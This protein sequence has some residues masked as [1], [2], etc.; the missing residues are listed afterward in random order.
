MHPYPPL[1]RTWT[2]LR[3]WLTREYPELGDTLNY[4]I[5]PEDLANL[6]LQLGCSLPSAVR[7]SYLI[8]DGQEAESAAGCSEGLFFGLW[9]LPLED[10]VEE[11]RFWREVD[12]DP[13]TGANENLQQYMQSIPPNW[14]RRRYSSRGWIPLISDKVGNYVGVDLSP[15]EG[16]SVGQVIVFGRD[17]DT[18]VVLWHGDGP[19]G[20]GRWL[21]GFVDEMEAG[22]TYEL[23]AN[24]QSEGSED[25][26]GY[27]SYFFDGSGR[28]QGDGGGDAGSGGL[29]LSGEYRGWHVLEAWAD[30]SMRKWHE[31]GLLPEP[32]A[33]T[34]AEK[35]KVSAALQLM[36]V[37]RDLTVGKQ[38]PA[39]RDSIAVLDLVSTTSGGSGAEVAIPVI[40]EADT[41]SATPVSSTAPRPPPPAISVTRPPAPKPVQLPTAHDL[42]ALPSPPDSEH[43]DNDDL[44]AGAPMRE[45]VRQYAMRSPAPENDTSDLIAVTPTQNSI[46]PPPPP[47]SQSSSAGMSDITDLLSDAALEIPSSPS[48]PLEPSPAAS[49]SRKLES[50]AFGALDL[51]NTQVDSA[52]PGAHVSPKPASPAAADVL[53]API[54]SDTLVAKPDAEDAAPDADTTIR[55]VGGGGVAGVVPNK[56]VELEGDTL[57][58]SDAASLSS[59]DSTASGKHKKKKSLSLGL[60]K[61]GKLGTSKRKESD[62]SSQVAAV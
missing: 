42:A 11:W 57:D 12:G 14:V 30:R 37:T 21:A 3:N 29:R 41:E 34:T 32:E 27:E 13:S 47:A 25:D 18:K 54:S 39:K 31:A 40:T 61:L 49:P 59:M 53:P 48:V 50:P 15:E 26:V 62:P 56:E 1:Q 45:V 44:E 17:F 7:E 36:T 5:L 46:T 8:S 43:G 10:V 58:A 33:P 2:R 51:N 16:G 38:G 23:T 24:E 52:R 35:G 20:W 9:L 4:G 28:G 60:K 22:E 19:G 6:E 55:L